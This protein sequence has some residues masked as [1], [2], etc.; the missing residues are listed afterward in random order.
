MQNKIQQSSKMAE[1]QLAGTEILVVRLEEIK[2]NIT[3][4]LR[5]VYSKRLKVQ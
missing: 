2:R 5:E 4:P 1:V 3:I